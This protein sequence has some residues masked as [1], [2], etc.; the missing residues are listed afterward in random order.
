[1]QLKIN[2]DL[3]AARQRDFA[4]KLFYSLMRGLAEAGREICDIGSTVEIDSLEADPIN[5]VVERAHAES[6]KLGEY[7]RYASSWGTIELRNAIS[8]FFAK[9][10][11][12]NIDPKTEVMVSRGIVD[13]V[14]KVIASLDITHVV[15]PSCAPYYA[16]T[17]SVL[18]RKEI[19]VAPLNLMTGSLDLEVLRARLMASGGVKG[20]VLMYITHP[21]APAGTAMSDRFIEN[22][23]I[24]FLR[25][26]GIWLV[27]DSYISA[28][29]FDGKT[30]RPILSFAG[31]KDVAVEAITVSK[32][33]GL[34]S[35]RAGGIA[36]NAQI[37]EAVRIYAATMIDTVA[38]PSQ[39]LAAMALDEIDPAIAG[40]RIE[41][42]LK[43]EILPRF[44]AMQW[45]VIVPKAGI[46]MLLSVPPGF[47]RRGV[48]DPALV[49]SFSILRRF[50]IAFFPCTVFSND[51][52]GRFNLRLVLKQRMGKIPRALD[53]LSKQGFNWRSDKPC[54]KDLAF[55][56]AKVANLDLTK[57]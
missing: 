33:L 24:P 5:Q 36:G 2:R 27:S 6:M 1:M 23:L 11:V 3:M 34:P 43:D 22:Q 51:K 56:R 29:R 26:N 55:L 17:F 37:I 52:S 30:I 21:S 54:E 25:K 40:N 28:T 19:I 47:I 9:R 38:L 16:E 4:A 13:S 20:K 44:E 53:S 48:R 14:D 32:E 42:E 46:D 31:A 8:G 49:A 10:G 7:S 12:S 39:R 45:P 15:I 35:A 57:L 18:R 50:G 41:Q